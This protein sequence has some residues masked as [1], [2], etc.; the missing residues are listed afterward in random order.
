MRP[1]YNKQGWVLC[2]C[3]S[4]GRLN[5]VEPHGTTAQCRCSKTWTEHEN[6]PFEAH[7]GNVLLDVRGEG[8]R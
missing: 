8:S 3:V 7:D 5:Y 4:C 1:R 6:L 2:R